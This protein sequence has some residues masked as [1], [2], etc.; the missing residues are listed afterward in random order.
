M[1]LQKLKS[2]SRTLAITCLAFTPIALA[3]QD[4]PTPAPK[5][6][7]GDYA[8]RWDIFAGYSYL[9]PHGTVNVPQANGTTIPFNYN[10]VNLGG[11]FSAAYYFNKYVGAQ[12]EVGFHEWGDGNGPLNN[13]GTHG[14]DDGFTTASGGIIFRYPTE[15]ITPFVHGLVGGALINGPDF[16]PNTWGP[17]LTVGGGMD[18]ATPF[19]NHHLAIRIF[20]AD[21]SYMHADFGPGVQGGQI[22]RAHV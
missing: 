16:N 15:D 14:N 9:A 12:A 21:Y 3:A 2:L 22:G 8:S 13:N 5:A 19:F 11:L 17:D 6:N 1:Y 4:A 7:Q 10:A 18:Y 20:Q